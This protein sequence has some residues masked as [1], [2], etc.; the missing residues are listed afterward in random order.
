MRGTVIILASALGAAV[1]AVAPAIAAAPGA[2][3]EDIAREKLAAVT[4]VRTKARRSTAAIANGRL[5]QAYL[6]AA[7]T[8]EAG[9]VK[10]RIVSSMK[11][12]QERYGLVRIRILWRDGRRLADIGAADKGPGQERALRDALAQ[13]PGKISGAIYGD[14]I[15]WTTRADREGAGDL[16]VAV[17]QDMSAYERALL[18]G[19]GHALHVIVINEAG[20]IVSDSDGTF[21]PGKPAVIGGLTPEAMRARLGITGPAGAGAIELDGRP[22]RIA[23]QSADGWTVIAMDKPV[24]GTSCKTGNGL[25]CR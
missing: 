6:S 1:A 22:V 13:E 18:H 9:R 4:L 3:I 25:P 24:P 8:S 15:N 12:M 11:A 14:T 5:L 17:G 7:T 21:T 2:S 19:L 23:I 10:A 20:R 16:V